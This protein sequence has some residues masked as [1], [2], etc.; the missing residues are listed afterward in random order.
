MKPSFQSFIQRSTFALVL[1]LVVPVG[2]AQA[3]IRFVAPPVGAPGNREAGT[4]RSETCAT[5]EAGQRLTTLIPDSNVGL[6]TK[7]LPT[8]FAYVPASNAEAAELNLY[9]AASGEEVYAGQVPLPEAAAGAEYRYRSAILKLSLPDGAL[10]LE[11]GQDYIWSL[12][13]VCDAAKPTSDIVAAGVVQRVDA[14]YLD[15]LSPALQ[16]RLAS[17]NGA[18]PADQLAT[19][20]EAG[21]WHELLETLAALVENNPGTYQNDWQALLEQQG[22]GAVADA[23]VVISEVQ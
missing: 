1:A 15:T 18:N 8:L 11:P 17:I 21:I 2:I 14:A 5:I 6:T 19:Y 12:A 13:L 22:L 23:L 10:T 7:A 20:G 3:Q 4:S 9:E 16:N